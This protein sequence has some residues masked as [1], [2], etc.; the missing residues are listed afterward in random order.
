MATSLAT[1]PRDTIKARR[2][3]ADGK[4]ASSFNCKLGCHFIATNGREALVSIMNYEILCGVPRSTAAFLLFC[5]DEI[6]A[7]EQFLAYD[8]FFVSSL[9]CELR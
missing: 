9:F 1:A 2:P 7:L 8:D 5:D 4:N 6:F 3:S